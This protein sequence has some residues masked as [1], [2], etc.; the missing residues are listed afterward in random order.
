MP[1][2]LTPIWL[3]LCHNVE[4]DSRDISIPPSSLT[5]CHA[6]C[7]YKVLRKTGKFMNLQ[8]LPF[9]QF[10]PIPTQ[11]H[12]MGDFQNDGMAGLSGNGA[13]FPLETKK[14]K[15]SHRSCFAENIR[16]MEN[17]CDGFVTETKQSTS[18]PPPLKD[19][20]QNRSN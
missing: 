13:D 8:K 10:I 19:L 15:K 9:S 3:P 16:N 18:S 17:K 2:E 6:S 11:S 7:N 4:V 14:K 1:P 12:F 5:D 20:D